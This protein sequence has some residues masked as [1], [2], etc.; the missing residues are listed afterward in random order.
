MWWIILLVYLVGVVAFIIWD[1]VHQ[2]P[3][4]WNQI[5]LHDLA[6][7]SL[8]WPILLVMVAVA[9][10]GEYLGDS[11]K[12]VLFWTAGGIRKLKDKF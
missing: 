3:E 9:L 11:T 10:T 1:V 8:I 4:H 7:L 6:V 5:D 2:N 12:K